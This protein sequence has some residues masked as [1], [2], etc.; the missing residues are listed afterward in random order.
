MVKHILI[1]I[2]D[3]EFEKMKKA[4]GKRTWKQV[5]GDGLKVGEK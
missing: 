4:K 3:S 5:L 1:D 2:D